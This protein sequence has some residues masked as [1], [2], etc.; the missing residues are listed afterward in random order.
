MR[1]RTLNIACQCPGVLLGLLMSSDVWRVASKLTLGG[2]DIPFMV[3]E[4]W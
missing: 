3:G 1:G 4:G 2:L